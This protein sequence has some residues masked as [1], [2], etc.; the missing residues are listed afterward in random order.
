MSFWK[1]LSRRN[2]VKIGAAYAVAAWLIVHPVDIIFP[3]SHLPERTKQVL[4]SKSIT[5]LIGKKLN[6]TN[7]SKR[8]AW[9]TTGTGSAGQ[10]CAIN[11]T[12]AI[13]SATDTPFG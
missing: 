5:H 2:V 4:L 7:S 8:S 1:E 6:L 12:M 13:L 11:W 9:S 3:T 10:T